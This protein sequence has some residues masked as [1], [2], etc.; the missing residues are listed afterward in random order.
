[1][2]LMVLIFIPHGRGK[3]ERR[4]WVVVPIASPP[5]TYLISM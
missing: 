4:L 5:I 2:I 1:M 3:M